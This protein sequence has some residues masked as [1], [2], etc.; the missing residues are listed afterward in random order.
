MLT[1]KLGAN[2]L[3]INLVAFLSDADKTGTELRLA[4]IIHITLP[5]QSGSAQN[6]TNTETIDAMTGQQL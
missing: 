1:V 4:Y 5:Y 6:Y 2:N 3:Q